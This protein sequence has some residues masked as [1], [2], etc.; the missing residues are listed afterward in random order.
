MND[1]EKTRLVLDYIRLTAE[2]GLKN[3]ELERIRQ[4][5]KL[6]HDEILK[7]GKE[8]LLDHIEGQ[9]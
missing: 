6:S 7:L 3:L 4:T 5:L 1:E 9:Q 2:D 8:K